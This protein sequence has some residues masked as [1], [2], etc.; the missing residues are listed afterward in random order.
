MIDINI[1][2]F[3][4]VYLEHL[5][6]DYNGTL[7][8]DGR[9]IKEVAY[10]L[11]QFVNRLHVHILTADTF[12]SV[13][14][15]FADSSCTVHVISSGQEDVKKADYV[16][17]LGCAATACIGNGRNDRLMLKKAALGIA[18]MQQEGLHLKHCWLLML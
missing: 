17:Q 13:K 3:G 6:L 4:E 8:F 18:V 2:G 11:E 12:G 16:E 10:L 1:P 15:M 14:K 7:A 5:V 9:L